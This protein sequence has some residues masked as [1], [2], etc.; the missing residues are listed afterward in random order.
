M[1]YLGFYYKTIPD[2]WQDYSSQKAWHINTVTGIK[3]HTYFYCFGAK[4]MTNEYLLF[5]SV[6]VCYHED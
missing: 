3:T 5:E 6:H 4:D 1:R 2:G